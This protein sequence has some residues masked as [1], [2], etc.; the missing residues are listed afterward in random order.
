MARKTPPSKPTAPEPPPRVTT[1]SEPNWLDES[2]SSEA[3]V[4]KEELRERLVLPADRDQELVSEFLTESREYLAQAE[5]ALLSLEQDPDDME[6]VGTVFRAFHTVKGVAAMLGIDVI[7]HFAHVAESLMSKVRDRELNFTGVVPQLALRS[8]DALKA[9]VEAVQ[10]ATSGGPAYLPQGLAGLTAEL[11]ERAH[12]VVAPASSVAEPGVLKPAPTAVQRPASSTA[13]APVAEAPVRREAAA[14]QEASVRV[15]TDRLD[16]L[17]DMVGELV[18]AQSMVSQD[19]TLGRPG[20]VELQKKVNHAGK[21]VRELQELSL[22]L[23][24]VP[25]RAAFQRLGRVV[26]DASV[27][28]GKAVRLRTEGEDTDIDRNMVDVLADPLV[29]ML[30]NAV[31]HGIET[32]EER[33]RAGKPRDGEI[34]LRA[35]HAGGN[36]VVELSDDGGGLD[37][38]RLIA[39]AISKGLI[40][41]GAG[42]SDASV[43]D[44]I[45]APGFSTAQQVTDLSGRGVGMDVVRRSVESLKGRIDISSTLGRGT[46][47]SI[48]VPLTLAITEGMLVRVGSERYLVPMVNIQLS[49][50]PTPSM[51][52]SVAGRGEMLMLRGELIPVFRLHRLYDVPDAETDP[53]Q[54]ILLVLSDSDGRC[55]L[56]VDEIL[57]QQQVVA[58]ALGETMGHVDGVSGGAILGDGRV[59]LI[60]DP[61][62]LKLLARNEAN[63]PLSLAS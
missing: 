62:E 52:S 56:M 23:R 30:R 18:I 61:P 9:L 1:G 28:S 14:A 55:A 43:Y 41:S 2:E 40:E 8:L 17:I 26:R 21:I 46:T 59:G 44:L 50:R 57:G 63:V 16:R 37:R 6:A 35:F 58:K 4:A 36:V 10:S 3:M 39:K 7:A 32:P 5:T 48:F 49:L 34:L 33:A 20:Q 38:E 51:L 60:L 27:K 47:F 31:D 45:F 54:A 15:R 25:L 53:S 12:G 24:M 11:Q 13:E 42:M 29:H 19:E 22:A